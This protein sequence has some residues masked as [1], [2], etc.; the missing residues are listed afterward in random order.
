MSSPVLAAVGA[1]A[2]AFAAGWAIG[3]EIY[4]AQRLMKDCLRF[5][6][7]ECDCGNGEL[8]PGESCDWKIANGVSGSCP[9]VDDA[10]EP[11]N[12]M[13]TVNRV[14]GD[15]MA[16]S[17][18]CEPAPIDYCE[19]GDGCCPVGCTNDPDAAYA[20]RDDDCMPV[21]GNG[22]REYQEECDGDD[23]GSLT[24]D[25]IQPFSGGV[26]KCDSNCALDTR[27][28]FHCGNGFIEPG[29]TCDLGNL[30]GASCQNQGAG[31]GELRC[32]LASECQQ[33][34]LSRCE[35][36]CGNGI[37]DDGEVCDVGLIPSAHS[38]ETLGFGPGELRCDLSNNC[39]SLDTSECMDSRD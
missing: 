29:E 3:D 23:F 25:A 35:G 10:C 26:I 27:E 32:D 6:D 5:Q 4:Q 21:C 34:D 39:S 7:Q 28:C 11:A 38:C 19:S 37:L 24:C 16:C 36:T 15:F 20:L 31:I 30:N 8:N 1:V 33:Y 18:R 22:K 2:G 12:E 14:V 17:E 13:C 9:M